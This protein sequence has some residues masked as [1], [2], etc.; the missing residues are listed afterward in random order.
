MDRGFEIEKPAGRTGERNPPRYSG[1]GR[2]EERSENWENE[3]EIP[4][5]GDW[6]LSRSYIGPHQVDKHQSAEPVNREG[7]GAVECP[8]KWGLRHKFRRAKL[9]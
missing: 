8:T 7:H 2:V 6:S 5:R 3:E 9:C 4:K 1:V